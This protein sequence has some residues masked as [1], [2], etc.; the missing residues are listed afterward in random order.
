MR[1]PRRYPVGCL[2]GH[3][4]AYLGGVGGHWVALQ[5][6]DLAAGA[7]PREDAKALR[8]IS[9]SREGA[10]A[11]EWEWV[12]RLPSPEQTKCAQSK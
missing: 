2:A 1:K 7:L 12:M 6:N 11:A 8:P 4:A 3:D 5:L 9:A 10:E